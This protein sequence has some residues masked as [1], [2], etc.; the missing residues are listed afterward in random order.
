MGSDVLSSDFLF[1]RPSLSRGFART[2]DLVGS[3]DSYN[4]AGSS[5]QADALAIYVDWSL[6]GADISEAMK[7]FSSNPVD[8]AGNEQLVLAGAEPR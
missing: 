2:L 4:W 6:V 7:A 5:E 1:V 3:L 8:L